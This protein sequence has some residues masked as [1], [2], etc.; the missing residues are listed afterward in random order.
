MSSR[1]YHWD[2]PHLIIHLRVQPRASRDEFAEVMGDWRRIRI[3]APP[4][5]GKANVYLC[6]FVARLFQVPCSS[7]T[8]CAGKTSRNKRLRV[9]APRKLP[10]DI[11]PSPGNHR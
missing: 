7:V 4:V 1:W 2:G 5:D 11:K 8:L 10:P 3:T 6:Q 9:T